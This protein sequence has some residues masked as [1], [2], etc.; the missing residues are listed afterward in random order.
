MYKHL[1]LSAL[2]LKTLTA[3]SHNSD[4]NFCHTSVFVAPRI[5]FLFVS[6][7]FFYVPRSL[8]SVSGKAPSFVNKLIHS[9]R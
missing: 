6:E 8:S 4:S 1:N 7:H 9:V 3:Q 2:Y 5:R